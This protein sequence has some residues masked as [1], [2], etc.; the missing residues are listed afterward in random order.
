L[1]RHNYDTRETLN[2]AEK[3][4]KTTNKTKTKKSETKKAFIALVINILNQIN[5]ITLCINFYFTSPVQLFYKIIFIS[6]EFSL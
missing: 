5:T 3:E 1:A 2:P 4:T 6:N